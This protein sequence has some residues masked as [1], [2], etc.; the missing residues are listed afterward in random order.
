LI[1]SNLIF[2]TIEQ[3]V[4]KIMALPS[5]SV[6]RRLIAGCPADLCNAFAAQGDVFPTF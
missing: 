4:G 5:E 3:N 1:L 2:D 6:L